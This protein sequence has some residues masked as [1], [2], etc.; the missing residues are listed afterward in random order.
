MAYLV[1]PLDYDEFR[2]HIKRL[3]ARSETHR[4]LSR[5]REHLN[6]CLQELN[7]STGDTANRSKMEL[8]SLPLLRGIAC[9]LSDLLRLRATITVEGPQQKLCDLLGCP[10]YG[11][12]RQ[13]MIQSIGVLEQSKTAMKSKQLM[14]LR[15]HLTSLL[16][17]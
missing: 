11:D 3:T 17:G 1:K 14:S 6:Q 4:T 15:L 12:F 5:V 10:E 13:T 7:A 16:E 8:L 9:C 2:E